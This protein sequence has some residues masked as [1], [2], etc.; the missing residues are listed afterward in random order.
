MPLPPG[1]P[2]SFLS[3][4]REKLIDG[5][6][7]VLALNGPARFTS[8]PD[9]SWGAQ[10]M[11]LVLFGALASPRAHQVPGAWRRYLRYL[12]GYV[13]AAVAGSVLLVWWFNLPRAWACFAPLWLAL[14]AAARLPFDSWGRWLGGLIRSRRL[15]VLAA[16]LTWVALF[17]F[18]LP[19]LTLHPGPPL[20]ATSALLLAWIVLQGY[21][22][23]C[24]PAQHLRY[25]TGLGLAA[26]LA[27]GWGGLWG[28]T[29]GWGPAVIYS[30]WLAGAIVATRQ[31]VRC[32]ASA[33]SDSFEVLRWV[34]LLW[35]TCAIL[36][37]FVSGVTCG[38]GDAKYYATFLADA[39]TQFRHGV[40][41]VFVGQ[42]EFQFNGAVIPIRVAPGYQYAGGLVD[43][44]TGRTLGV[45]AVQNLLILLAGAAGAA[46]AYACARRLSR[47]GSMAWLLTALFLSCPGVAAIAFVSDL[48]M[49]WLTLP[50][51]PLVLY[52]GVDS[53]SCPSPRRLAG[54]GFAL[55]VTWWLHAPVALWL[56][57]ASTALQLIRIGLRRPAATE[58][59]R[60]IVA[61]AGAFAATAA[62]PLVS[63]ILYPASASVGSGG[64]LLVRAEDV[65]QELQETFPG[66]WLPV[67]HFGRLL[68]DFQIGYGLLLLGALALPAVWRSRRPELRALAVLAGTLLLLLVP[69]PW[70][71]LALWKIVPASVRL[72][73]NI[74]VMQRLYL[75]LAGCLVFL[76][77]GGW[78]VERRPAHWRWL[79]VFASL[80]SLAETGKF[81]RGSWALPQ[82][83]A[84]LLAP[85]NIALTRY[86]YGLFGSRPA[87]FTH[88]VTDPVLEN[89][90]L[91]PDLRTVIGGNPAVAA[92]LATADPRDQEA[93]RLDEDLLRLPHAVVLRPGRRYLAMVSTSISPFPAATLILK[94][95][96]FERVYGLPEYGEAQSFGLAAGHPSFFPL[97]TSSS[98][99]EPIEVTLVPADQTQLPGLQGRVWLHIAEYPPAALPVQVES[100]LP[101]RATVQADGPA[102]LETPR[103]YQ[104]GY[105]A[106]VDGRAV[107]VKGSAQ[108]LAC[109]PV[110][111]GH[112]TVELRYI[113]PAGLALAFWVSF[114]AV[115]GGVVLATMSAIR[116]LIRP[117]AAGA[118]PA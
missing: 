1:A 35:M 8:L 70:L 45:M 103:M 31:A 82:G 107:E 74:W 34:G 64:G 109:F 96:T 47:S 11:V 94:G 41:P 25:R 115:F 87:Y 108:G 93:F 86:S 110:P 51:V 113:A 10:L 88:G 98:S 7:L 40:F 116:D 12:P 49:S 33:A 46:G 75:I 80:W 84:T 15:D 18:A 17:S 58:F 77:A 3:R 65:L 43:L 56:T 59:A 4:H 38:G 20:A 66:A 78:N 27:L 28:P 55:G 57:L 67:S 19:R 21:T 16:D 23:C 48:Y 99:A 29:I 71:N 14:T 50:W 101:Y 89:R 69:I 114:L 13:G 112:S 79:L 9:V 52:L 63:A 76:V 81:L 26:G 83:N 85:E 91:A 68:S 2:F 62:Y 118:P 22:R 36:E 90:F 95:P 104:R 24:D 111:A 30:A 5:A 44:L 105:R 54:L 106:E 32:H 61:G 117:S 53:F 6:L 37:P 92:R 72:V 102:W 42:S 97:H 60:Q 100:W 39:L 73:T